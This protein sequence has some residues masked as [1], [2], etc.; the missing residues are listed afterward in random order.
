MD[1]ALI[2]CLTHI[3]RLTFYYETKKSSCVVTEHKGA[4][5]FVLLKAQ[6][7]R[8]NRLLGSC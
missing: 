2:G 5:G 3:H 6:K 1:S 4:A 7:V 8:L